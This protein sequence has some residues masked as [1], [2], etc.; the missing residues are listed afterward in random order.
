[1]KMTQRKN[2]YVNIRVNQEERARM[3]AAALVEQLK[4]STW[5]RRIGLLNCGPRRKLKGTR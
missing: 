1:M 4:I 2:T 5:L 3:E